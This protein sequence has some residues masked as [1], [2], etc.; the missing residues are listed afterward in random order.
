MNG[1]NTS[2]LAPRALFTL[3]WGQ[4]GISAW[5]GIVTDPCVE[6]ASVSEMSISSLNCKNKH[7]QL[8]CSY[9]F[10]FMLKYCYT[11]LFVHM[12]VF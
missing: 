8:D 6:L 3:T 2:S 10:N 7:L 11:S 1:Y 9:S 12:Y 5:L 4:N